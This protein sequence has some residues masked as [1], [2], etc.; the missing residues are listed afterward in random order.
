MRKPLRGPVCTGALLLSLL[1]CGEDAESGA[2]SANTSDLS[3][4]QPDRGE[5]YQR[6]RLRAARKAAR[7]LPEGALSRSL[8]GLKAEQRSDGV[9]KVN[10]EG[11]FQHASVAV[12][13]EH[14]QARATCI[15]G[16]AS[17]KA[18]QAAP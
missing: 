2:Q 7:V 14:G 9:V 13:D 15:D 17:A 6:E 11:R 18:T 12:I 16:P 8:R 5:T 3:H 1:G 4:A 10:L